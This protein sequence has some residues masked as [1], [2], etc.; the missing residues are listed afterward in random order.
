VDYEIADSWAILTVR[1][2]TILYYEAIRGDEPED[3]AWAVN[4]TFVFERNMQNWELVSH[5]LLIDDNSIPPINEPI[6]RTKNEMLEIV[7]SPLPHV[8][9]EHDAFLRELDIE[10]SQMGAAYDAWVAEL[11]ESGIALL[12]RTFN[13]QAAADYALRWALVRNPAFRDFSNSG[14]NCTNFISQAM[15]AGGW[16]HVTGFY[17]NA[18]HWWYNSLNQTRSWVNVNQ[19]HDFASV[20]SRRTSMLTNPRSLWVGEVLQMSWDG[21]TNKNHTA[22]VTHRTSSDIYLSQN[23]TDRRNISFTQYLLLVGGHPNIRW[24]PHLVHTSF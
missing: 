5:R 8:N 23:T 21:S 24:F 20:H 22:I 16:T 15:D 19:W 4:R 1:E 13:R 6:N 14:G 11:D 17:T 7:F 3:T 9:D 10:R 2:L 12:N 18:N